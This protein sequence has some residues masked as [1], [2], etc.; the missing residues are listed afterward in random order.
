M[1]PRIRAYFTCEISDRVPLLFFFELQLHEQ[2]KSQ[3][4]HGYPYAS[5]GAVPP[6]RQREIRAASNH[7]NRI[8]NA[9]TTK[10]AKTDQTN[11]RKRQT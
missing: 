11:K 4:V 10:N 8:E 6:M 2:S 9:T 1:P 5:L 7:Q 3:R